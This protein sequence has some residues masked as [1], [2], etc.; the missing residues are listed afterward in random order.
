[1]GVLA[2]AALSLALRIPS[3]SWG[4]PFLF[5]PD[6]PTNFSI[7]QRMLKQ[8]DLNPHF[9][10]Y[11]SLFFYAHA[12]VQA[13]HYA[14]CRLLGIVHSVQALPEVDVPIDGSGFT[15]LPSAFFA[16]RLL[17]LVC[18][19]ALVWIAHELGR[20]LSEDARVGVLAALL[21]AVSPGTLRDTR[22]MSPDAPVTLAVTS[23]VL[24]ALIVLRTGR[25]KDYAYAAILCG[26]TAS[27]K[28][29][30]ALV[31]LTIGIAAFLREGRGAIRKPWLY[32][33]PVIAACCFVLTSPYALLD[34]RNFRRDFASEAAHYAT[35]HAGAEGDTL[36]YYC[37]YLLE[38]EGLGAVFALGGVVLGAVRRNRGVLLLSSFC[39]V[40]F[41]FINSFVTRN[42][43][44]IVPL[45]PVSLVIAAWFAVECG[46]GL[47]V[48]M[49]KHRLGRA[50]RGT[51][52]IAA[53]AAVVGYPLARSIRSTLPLL[54]KDNRQ[55]A[56]DWLQAHVPPQA[57]IAIERYSCYVNRKL[58]AL[59]VTRNLYELDPSWLKQ[60]VDYLIFAGDSFNRYLVDP[61]R[62]RRQAQK[63][64]RLFRD[65]ELVRTFDDSRRGAEIRIYRTARAP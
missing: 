52:T 53:V 50:L 16:G 17:S 36:A 28:Y 31:G 35:G 46:R 32:A 6:E 15:A 9:F 37:R 8:H 19:V 24:A 56:G 25:G 63:Y 44:T 3:L 42:G 47:A 7:V 58:Y 39:V 57:R 18:G 27:L 5:H 20:A 61:G 4:L 33:A 62:Y 30:G 40:Y 48:M 22:W 41:C 65:F 1:M 21:V 29:N 60:H 2:C 45:I 26:V 54:R 13:A 64:E 23:T 14:G 12:L 55:L 59:K 51:V 34:F 11:P 43:R 49:K 38:G 10:K